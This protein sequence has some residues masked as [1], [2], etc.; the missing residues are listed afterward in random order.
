MLSLPT[1]FYLVV[2]AS[3][4]VEQRSYSQTF[5]LLLN[6]DLVPDQVSE[7]IKCRSISGTKT[8]THINISFILMKVT[9]FLRVYFQVLDLET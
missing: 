8:N 4:R 5:P 1:S 6:S 3:A 7:R 2:P 9:M